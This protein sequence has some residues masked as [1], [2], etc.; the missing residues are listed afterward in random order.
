MKPL[1]DTEQM[2]ADFAITTNILCALK[3]NAQIPTDDIEVLTSNGCVTLCGNLQWD[4]Q[5]GIVQG[6]VE[7]M[8]GVKEFKNYI[9]VK[10]L[11]EGRSIWSFS[12]N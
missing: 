1:A 11:L 7:K 8:A 9:A 3:V 4:F 5:L 12:A 10:P 6:L 2:L